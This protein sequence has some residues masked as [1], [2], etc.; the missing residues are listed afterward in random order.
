MST[1]TEIFGTDGHARRGR[2]PLP[3][4]ERERRAAVRKVESKRRTEAR[5]RALAV[6][7]HRHADELADLVAAEYAALGLDD[8]FKTPVETA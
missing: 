1:Y 5:R 7:G 4:E 3:A 8:R 2:P 6:L